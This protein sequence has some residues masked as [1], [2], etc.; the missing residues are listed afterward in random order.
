M[1]T[2]EE[3]QARIDSLKIQEEAAGRG[4]SYIAASMN[5]RAW[6]ALEWALEEP[7][8]DSTVG[9]TQQ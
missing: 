6:R 7:E 8:R 3:I 1:R 9:G 5:R 4:A 2:V